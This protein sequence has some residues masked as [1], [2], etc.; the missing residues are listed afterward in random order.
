MSKLR[1]TLKRLES[2]FYNK[3]KGVAVRAAVALS[4]LSLF[5]I[6]FM[7]NTFRPSDA[8]EYAETSV[9]V[10]RKSLRG[11]GSGVILKSTNKGSIILTNS[12][13]CHAVESGGFVIV[14]NG[15][16]YLIREYKHSKSH[17][18]CLVRIRKNLGID[19]KVSSFA[20]KKYAEAHISGH[21]SLLPHVVTHGN[22]SG[23]MVIDVVVGTRPCTKKEERM[24]GPFCL[25]GIPIIKTYESQL[26]TGT[27]M[28]GSSGSAVYNND[29]E[30]SA[31]IFAGNDRGLSYGF[32]VPHDYVWFF[33]NVEARALKWEKVGKKK[34]KKKRQ[35][36]QR[37]FPPQVILEN[38]LPKNQ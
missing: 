3:Y 20:P 1:R 14:E 25:F 16:K 27:I 22:F 30:I 12:H 32:A 18:L 2:K 38:I 6:I 10:V 21:P 34:K 31:I 9:R 4:V 29:G 33:V 15:A 13:V 17:D 5:S 19:T 35:S 26:I 7:D 8:A 11:G 24:A 28:P 23:R 36:H 37:M